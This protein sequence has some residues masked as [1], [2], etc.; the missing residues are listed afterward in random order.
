MT[1]SSVPTTVLEFE[2]EHDRYHPQSLISWW[3]QDRLRAATVMVVGAGA[4]GNEIVKNLAL[5]GVGRIVVAD[6]D[7]IENSNLA[8]CVFFRESDEGRPKAEVLAARAMELNPDV[9]VVAVT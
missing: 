8:R 5:A 4:L 2:D 6:F 3:D 9:D 7:Q 1:L